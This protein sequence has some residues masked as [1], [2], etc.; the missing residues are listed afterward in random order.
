MPALGEVGAGV[1]QL[2]EDGQVLVAQPQLRRS[3]VGVDRLVIALP[4]KETHGQLPYAQYPQRVVTF[5]V[6]GT[7]C[8][9]VPSDAQSIAV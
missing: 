1:L 4:A 8:V 6:T 3:L 7:F 5:S 2:T 9:R